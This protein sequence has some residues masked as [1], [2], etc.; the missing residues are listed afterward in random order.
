MTS[1]IMLVLPPK[2]YKVSFRTVLACLNRFWLS[3]GAE[4]HE[5]EAIS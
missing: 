1:S 2:T 5:F 4:C 3:D